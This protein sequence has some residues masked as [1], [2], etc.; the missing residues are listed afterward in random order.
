MQTGEPV[1][2]RRPLHWAATL[3]RIGLGALF[4]FA[5]VAKLRD[6]TA[7]ATEIANYRLVPSLAPYL[8]TTLPTVELV[9]GVALVVGPL[10]WRRAAAVAAM[11]LLA[12]FT[13]AVVHVVRSGINVECGCFG[14][15][16]GPVS[17]W[18][19]ARDLA[20]LAAAA[21]V[22]RDTQRYAQ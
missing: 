9:V 1:N 22:F 15:S 20:L 7:F 2:G 8:A 4:V 21:F 13:V 3:I 10:L 5:G 14:G 17:G 11:A 6:P 12:M 19:V 18:T 16:S